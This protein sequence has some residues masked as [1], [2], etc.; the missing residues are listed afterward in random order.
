MGNPALVEVQAIAK[1]LKKK[2]S[3]LKHIEAVKLAWIKYKK[4]HPKKEE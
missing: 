2:D 3:N 4:D 1:E